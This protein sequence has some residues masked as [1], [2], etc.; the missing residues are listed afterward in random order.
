MCVIVYNLNERLSQGYTRTFESMPSTKTSSHGNI[1][2]YFCTCPTCSFVE[3]VQ[4]I[5]FE[6]PAHHIVAGERDLCVET[7]YFVPA[8]FKQTS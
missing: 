1:I 7:N 6:L 5:H 2:K 4:M 3:E 8:H